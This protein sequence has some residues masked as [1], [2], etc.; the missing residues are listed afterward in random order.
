MGRV[1]IFSE[2]KILSCLSSCCSNIPS[3][4]IKCLTDF[5]PVEIN[6]SK[7]NLNN[8][9]DHKSLLVF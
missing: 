9:F 7:F 8:C 3:P 1:E 5:Y 6:R 2:F 4:D